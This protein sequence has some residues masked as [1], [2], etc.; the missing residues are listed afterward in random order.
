[1]FG[2][3]GQRLV[4]FFTRETE[5]TQITHPQHTRILIHSCFRQGRKE[6]SKETR[7]Q[8]N[9]NDKGHKKQEGKEGGGGSKWE[10]KG[11]QR[12]L[13]E[14]AAMIELNQRCLCCV[15]FFF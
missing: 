9:K 2:W 5:Q 13:S 12:E 10:N 7:Q 11:R 6:G 8:G 1:M 4:F 3:E 15:P 14:R